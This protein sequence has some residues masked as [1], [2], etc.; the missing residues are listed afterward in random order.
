MQVIKRDG[1]E[2]PY[3]RNR[4]KSAVLKA[5]EASECGNSSDVDFVTECI[6]NEI[7]VLSTET[8]GV[9]IIQDIVERQL[10]KLGYYDVAKAYCVYRDKRSRARDAKNNLMRNIGEIVN[11]DARKNNQKRENANIDGNTAM[12][13]MLQIGSACSRAYN[14]AYLMRPEHAKAHREGDLHIHD[15]DFYALTTTCCQIDILKLFHGGFSTGHGFLR[16][17]QSIQSYAALAAIAI[18]ANQNDQHGGQSIPNFDYGMAEGVEKSFRRNFLQKLRDM[19]E[20]YSNIDSVDSA[21]V[22][23]ALEDAEKSSGE[24]LALGSNIKL[25][26][27]LAS[28]F[29]TLSEKLIERVRERAIQATERDTYQAM[30]GFVH[31]LNTMH[32]RAGAQV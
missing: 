8:I 1:R 23:K 25:D 19:L 7:K 27:V 14:E 15:C 11:A 3:E 6:E 12:G 29:L 22:E 32:S 13:A 16:E 10:M 21:L 28:K 26:V 4:I 18:Q 20:D 5:M 30:E 2:V 31:N 24:T 17:P 9:E